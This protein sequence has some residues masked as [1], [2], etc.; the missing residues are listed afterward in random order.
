MAVINKNGCDIMKTWIRKTVVGMILIAVAL[1]PVNTMGAE[2]KSVGMFP[3]KMLSATDSGELGSRIASMIS[4][5][6]IAEGAMVTPMVTPE[7]VTLLEASDLQ[8]MGLGQGMDYLLWGTVFISGEKISMDMK[9]KDVIAGTRPVSFFSEAQGVETLFSAVN[10]LSIE[11]SGEIFNR[12]LI[13]KISVKGNI[14][15]ESDAILKMLH[16]A[17]GDIYSPERLSSDLKAIYGM[18]YFNDVRIER[19]DYDNG[20][21]IIYS[22]E[23][24]PS[25]RKVKFQGNRI[26][27]EQELFDVVSTSTGSILNIYKLKADVAAIQTLYTD[28]N[29]HNCEIDYEL[30]LLENNQADIVFIIK[31]GKKLR[32]ETLVLEGNTFFSRKQI[33]KNIKTSE[34]GF[35]SWITS[36]GDLDRNELTQDVYRMEAFYKNNGFIDARISDPEIEF[37]EK[38]IWVKFK[39]QEGEQ[40]RIGEISFKGDLIF[41]QDEL[42]SGLSLKTDALYSRDLLRSNMLSL[43]D[44][45]ADKGFANADVRPS[46]SRDIETKKV[47]IL[48][49]VQKGDPVYFERIQITG[50]TKTRDKVIRRQVTVH[51]QEL[52]SLSGIQRSTANLRR[53]DYFENV[54]VKPSQGSAQDK[55]NLNV[56]ITEKP[57]GAFSFGGGYSS[58][59]KIFGMISVSERNFRGKGQIASLKAEVSAS[60]TKYTFSFTEPWLFD[61]PLSAGIDLYKWDYEYD[62]YDKDSTGGALRFG[63]KIFDYT[64]LGLKYGYEDFTIENV[65]EYYTDVD[66]GNYVTSS[67]TTS[68]RY[69]SRNSGFNPTKGSEHSVSVEYA[70]GW[71]GGE[72]DFTKYIA[73]TGWYYPLFWKF[74][75][76][77]HGRGGFLDDRSDGDL[78]IDYERFYLGGINSVRGYDWQDINATPQGQTEERGGEK[79]LQFNAEVTFPI[80]EDMKLMGVVFYDAGDVYEKSEDIEFGDLYTSF[81]G[82]IRWYSPMGPIRIEYGSILSGNEYTGGRWEFSMGGTF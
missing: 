23:E 48:F 38:G 81:G 40:F 80:I 45:Y 50:N 2:K 36:S 69:D 8:T 51:E 18:G 13:E 22:V 73:E 6:V 17:K 43:T 74:T 26:Y 44:R 3:L 58:E 79:F 64:S 25:V 55:V 27:D 20:L 42:M 5:N 52:Y 63:Y 78:D 71:L 56:E 35:W 19:Q 62:Y 65:D 72:I 32:I 30:K 61:I 33:L 28:K 41:P 4:D 12:K 15:I 29:Y 49:D 34:R 54:E 70:G 37:K 10:A 24:K 75:G 66:A 16:T 47:N 76:F 59:D 11:I 14:R 39:I 9:V 46:I 57:T 31:E 77:L 67:I 21:E 60:S 68:L 53:I 1:L 82:G 7:D